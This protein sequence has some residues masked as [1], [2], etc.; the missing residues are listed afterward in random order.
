MTRVRLHKIKNLD[1]DL[2]FSVYYMSPMISRGINTQ[3]GETTMSKMF[4]LLSEN[5]STLKGKN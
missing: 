4:C 3:S 2:L 1:L 5:R